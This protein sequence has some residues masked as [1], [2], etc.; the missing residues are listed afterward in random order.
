ML[1][2]VTFKSNKMAAAEKQV[3]KLTSRY[4]ARDKKFNRLAAT[5]CGTHYLNVVRRSSAY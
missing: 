1:A 2:A 3:A 5:V 4:D